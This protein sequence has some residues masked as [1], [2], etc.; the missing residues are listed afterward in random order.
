MKSFSRTQV[1]GISLPRILI[2]T[3]WVLGYSHRSPSADNMI[4]SKY[5]NKEAVA[6]L[7]EAYLQY[8]ID[9]IMAPIEENSILLNGIRMAEDKTGKKITLINTP[10]VDVSDSESGRKSAM[11][12]IEANA[13]IGSD[14]CLVHHSSCEQLISKLHGTMDRLPDYLDMIRQ[15]GMNPG[16]SAHMPEVIMYADNNEYDVETY[17]Q[18]YNCMGFLMQVEVENVS[19]VIWNAKKPVMTIKSMAAG[20]CSPYV[21]ITYNFATI[22][23]CDMV[24][25][26]AHTADEVHEDVEIA[27]AALEKRYPQMG[28]RN[29]PNKTEVL[30]W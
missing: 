27:L 11:K 4:R 30:G 29:S 16:L 1:A 24:T 22:R 12:T 9:A 14:F 17:I 6:E 5:D 23:E 18:P 3:N 7:I 26:G 2:G 19:R 15:N 8:D 13:K 10:I 20:R 28:A 21:G 25:I